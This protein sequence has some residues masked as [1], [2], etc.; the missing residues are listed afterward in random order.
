MPIC[1]KCWQP[2]QRLQLDIGSMFAICGYRRG[3]RRC[4][5]RLHLMG[6]GGGV[7]V[8]VALSDVEYERYTKQQ[9]LIAELYDDLGILATIDT[10]GH[11]PAA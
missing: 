1:P 11:L 9:H 2:V 4:G 8:V 10:P 6:T 7:C 3:G 5:Q